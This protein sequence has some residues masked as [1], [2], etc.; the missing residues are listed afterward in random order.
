[1]HHKTKTLLGYATDDEDVILRND[2]YCDG[3]EEFIALDF[4][5][6]KTNPEEAPVRQAKEVPGDVHGKIPGITAF[7]KPSKGL[8]AV[9]KT[10]YFHTNQ[11]T[12]KAK[13]D[14]QRLD[15]IAHYLKR[16]PKMYIFIE[17]HCDER[18][19]EALNLSLGTRRSNHTRAL[20]IKKG[21]NPHHIFTV[22][23]GKERPAIM[24][25]TPQAWAQNRRVAFKIYQAT[26]DLL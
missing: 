16:H 3:E 24:G 10:I 19:S 1:M 2:F 25:H 12:P 21:V 9:F 22:S 7:H 17:G 8:E 4:K 14:L 6:L 26:Q 20:L 13:E 15:Q 11:H 18:G 5:D 23:Y